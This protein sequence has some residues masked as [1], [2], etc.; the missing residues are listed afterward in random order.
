MPRARKAP[1]PPDPDRLVR[2]QAG[3]YRTEDD[4]FEV[5]ES[6]GDWFLVDTAQSD[7]LGQELVRGP[8]PTLAA[9]RAALP[10]ARTAAAKAAPRAKARR[11]SAGRSRATEEPGPPDPEPEPE[12]E[13]E[14]PL[15]VLLREATRD[16]FPPADLEVE[17]MP[18]PPG[19]SDAV[20]AFSGHNVVAADVSEASVRRRLPKNDPGAP[21][22]AGFLTWLGRQLGSEPGMLD[23]VLVGLPAWA[24]PKPLSLAGVDTADD[25]DRVRRARQ[26]R[27]DVTVHADREERGLVILGRGLAGR[28]EVSIEVE[29]KHRGRG[30]GA[31][32]ARAALAL[33]EA[34]EP[35]FAQVSPGNVASLR[36]FLAAGYRPIGSEV[37]FLRDR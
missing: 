23:I 18:A 17:V 16:R 12:P 15:V 6:G 25:H 19:P 11:A 35:L 13:P 2:Q 14:H 34:G 3:T 27:T 29:P 1:A 5:R 30:L 36:A 21:M 37:L 20:V 7:D 8:F 22:S 9:I 26:Y 24:P 4:R 10:D 33:V 28:L 31:D 32:L